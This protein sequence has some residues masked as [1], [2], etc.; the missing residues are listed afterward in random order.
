MVW[1]VHKT[2]PSWA[3]SAI[4]IQFWQQGSLN[5]GKKTGLAPEHT[6][7]MKTPVVPALSP[8]NT[9][10][11]QNPSYFTLGSNSYSQP[12]SFHTQMSTLPPINVL[13]E[14][15]ARFLDVRAVC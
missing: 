8:L 14:E 10:G 2:T 15:L 13:T 1:E 3:A 9:A 4:F 5:L 6:E 7:L 12:D 11:M